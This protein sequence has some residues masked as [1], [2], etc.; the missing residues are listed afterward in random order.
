MLALLLIH[1]RLSKPIE[2]TIIT[3]KRKG[4]LSIFQGLLFFLLS[5]SLSFSFPFP[6]PSVGSVFR[7]GQC[8]SCFARHILNGSKCRH[9]FRKSSLI[10]A[11][12]KNIVFYSLRGFIFQFYRKKLMSTFLKIKPLRPLLK[13]AT[14]R[15][16]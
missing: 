13:D 2:G 7:T 4:V 6:L 15:E 11:Y 5:S 1:F 10:S 3:R 8:N 9:L 14:L 16:S 12:N